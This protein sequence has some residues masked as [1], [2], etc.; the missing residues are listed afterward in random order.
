MGGLPGRFGIDEGPLAHRRAAKR[1]G[2]DHLA[3]K[4][5]FKVWERVTQPEV[6]E[7]MGDIE[8]DINASDGSTADATLVLQ[9]ILGAPDGTE[10]L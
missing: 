3:L 4:G 5:Q 10:E 9:G 8:V 2:R 7:A 1:S 6:T